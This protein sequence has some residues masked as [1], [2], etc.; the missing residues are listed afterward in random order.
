[1]EDVVTEG[2]GM[3][4]PLNLT[5]E[6]G[7]PGGVEAEN[8]TKSGFPSDQRA[9]EQ[10][11]EE[12]EEEEE[13]EEGKGGGGL[14]TNLI[15]TMATPLGLTRTGKADTQDELG[16]EIP[17]KEDE[18][19]DDIREGGGGGGGILNNIIS[20]LFHQ[21]D[22]EQGEKMEGDEEK[23]KQVKTAEEANGGVIENIISHL[24]SSIPDDAVPTADEA[25][26]LINS[27][28]RD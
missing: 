24:P 22:D 1:M 20:N 6:E 18:G 9:R 5:A 23:N 7:R 17:K 28:V 14:I 21:S 10:R 27:L 4:P 19:H 26:I 13:E 25:T 3:L 12:Q 2:E 15:S 11:D 8:E 16:N